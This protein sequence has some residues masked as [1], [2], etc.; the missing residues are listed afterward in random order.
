MFAL[1]TNTLICYFKGMGRV[2]ACLQSHKPFELAIPIAVLYEIETGLAKST[3]PAKRRKQ[4]DAMLAIVKVLPFDRAA[5]RESATLRATLEARGQPLG[6]MDYLIAGISLA[7][8]ATLV[9][10]NTREF[11]RVAKLQIVD[12][13]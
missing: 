6:A 13:F 11:G 7:N 8:H 1:D 3:N 12:W 9:T 5:V 10:H 2:A 4:L